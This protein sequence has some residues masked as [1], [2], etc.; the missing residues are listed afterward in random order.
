[1][2]TFKLCRKIHACTLFRAFLARHRG[3]GIDVYG[4]RQTSHSDGC[5]N[6]GR[7]TGTNWAT[8]EVN[9]EKA[10]IRLQLSFCW[11]DTNG[12]TEIFLFPLKKSASEHTASLKSLNEAGVSS[13]LVMAEIRLKL[14]S[15]IKS[16]QANPVWLNQ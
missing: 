8:G 6:K 12:V 11:Q 5:D 10:N 9:V 3:Y 13:A 2:P 1:M 7:F 14:M 15:A 16:R 4:L